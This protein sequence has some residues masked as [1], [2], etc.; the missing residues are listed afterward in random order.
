MISRLKRF[1]SWL[2]APYT[3]HLSDTPEQ[4]RERRWWQANR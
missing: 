2:W 3:A 4:A 1:W